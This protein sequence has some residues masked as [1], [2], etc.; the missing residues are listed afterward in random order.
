MVTL[1]AFGRGRR[2]PAP[3]VPD[4]PPPLGSSE[5]PKGMMPKSEGRALEVSVNEDRI[6]LSLSFPAPPRAYRIPRRDDF[7]IALPDRADAK[8]AAVSRQGD[9]IQ[10]L[11]RQR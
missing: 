1:G 2:L 5:G 3:L 9:K 11:F 6:L 8:T 7:V 4:P 10:I